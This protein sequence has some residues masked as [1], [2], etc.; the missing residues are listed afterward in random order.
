ASASTL[1]PRCWPTAMKL[2]ETWL[3]P[4][5]HARDQH[6]RDVFV[7]GPVERAHAPVIVAERGLVQTVEDEARREA[8]AEE[9]A[10]T[11]VK[12]VVGR[13]LAEHTDAPHRWHAQVA[14]HL[15]VVGLHELPVP[16]L[17]LQRQPGPTGVVEGRA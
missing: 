13:G 9:D 10:E 15:H 1:M 4:W 7:V 5:P 8:G 11:P 17:F 6:R 14:G 16:I 3:F 2:S 12:V